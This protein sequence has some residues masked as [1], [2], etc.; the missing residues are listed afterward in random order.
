M[1]ETMRSLG[2]ERQKAIEPINKLVER[3]TLS[4]LLHNIHTD[5]GIFTFLDWWGKHE[6]GNQFSI[7]FLF[8]KD[9]ELGRT[10]HV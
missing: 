4:Y 10:K 7:I 3:Q 1:I 2:I 5:Q 8:K 9:Y 6:K